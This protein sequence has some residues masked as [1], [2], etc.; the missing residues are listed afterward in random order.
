MIEA[1][2]FGDVASVK[3]FEEICASVTTNDGFKPGWTPLTYAALNGHVAVLRM[4]VEASVKLGSSLNW[5]E[6]CFAGRTC[7]SMKSVAVY[8]SEGGASC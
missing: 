5:P 7:G 4:L 2:K 1:T 6:C 3:F 8:G